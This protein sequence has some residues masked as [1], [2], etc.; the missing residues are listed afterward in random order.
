MLRVGNKASS[1]FP[2]FLNKI[3]RIIRSI[4]LVP[5]AF[6]L[7]D[8]GV[9]LAQ[10]VVEFPIPSSDS[11]PNFITTGPDGNLWFLEN[12]GNRVARITPGGTITEFA[13][14]P[15][16]FSG[17]TALAAGPDGAVWFAEF[18]HGAIGR[19]S[20]TGAV[21]EFIVPTAGSEPSGIALGGDGNLW[22]T[23]LTFNKIGQI[24]PSGAITEFRLAGI[25]NGFDGITNGPDGNLWF[26]E[27][28][29]NRIAKVST[30]GAITEVGNIPTAQS[31]PQ[32]IA[33]GADGNL[34]FTENAG[35]QIGRITTGGAITEFALPTFGAPS[36]ITPGPDG[37]LWYTDTGTNRIGRIT[38]AGAISEFPILSGISNLIGITA[39]PDGALWFVEESANK[40]GRLLPSPPVALVSAVLPVSRSIEVNATATAFATIINTGSVTA[41]ACR[42]SPSIALPG[43]FS[44]QTTNPA[45]NALTGQQ[46]TPVD[47]PAGAPQSFVFAFTPTAA[48]AATDVSLNFFCTNSDGAPVISGLSTILL[49]AST[50]PV[51]DVIALVASGDP[52]IVD[53][54]GATGTGVFALASFNLGVSATITVTADTGSANLPVSFILCETN[55][56]SGQC[57][58]PP[59]TS[60]T[61]TIANSATPTFSVFVTGAATIPFAPG[62]SRAFVRFNDA[63]G[64]T[65]GSSSIAIRTQ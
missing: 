5:L 23:E 60:V 22:F 31:S 52:G 51:P 25:G 38:T 39:G 27:F 58:A 4:W 11:Q 24:T 1:Y 50:T 47:I 55:P 54:P 57:L 35:G 41:T 40:I 3:S 32:R 36:D 20:A 7:S 6:V 44:Y 12:A 29:D 64:V 30:G 53:I 63:N 61:T 28:D 21:S 15:N 45:T 26:T 2:D 49:S 14:L 19:I 18:G 9:G 48:L 59:A 10:T 13:T 43:I 17:P 65:R 46:N 8:G 16:A 33:T 56:T 37:A 34:W 42:L 62:T